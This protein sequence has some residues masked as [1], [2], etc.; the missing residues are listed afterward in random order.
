M[1]TR[2]SKKKRDKIFFVKKILPFNKILSTKNSLET[3]KNL[4]PFSEP[5]M[6]TLPKNNLKN[7]LKALPKFHK[8]ITK[9]I[10][11]LFHNLELHSTTLLEKH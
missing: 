9:L 10:Q 7:C 4:F 3:P 1:L 6:T 5:K 11:T 2:I 8:K